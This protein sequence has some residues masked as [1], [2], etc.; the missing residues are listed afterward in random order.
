MEACC[1]ESRLF[2]NHRLTGVHIGP[3]P[4]GSEV[5]GASFVQGRGRI[6]VGGPLGNQEGSGRGPHLEQGSLFYES[7]QNQGG[8]TRL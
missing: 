5:G 8:L 2:V 3:G 7:G 6:G 4:R 1:G